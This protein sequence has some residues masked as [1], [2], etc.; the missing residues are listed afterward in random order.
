M[1]EKRKKTTKSHTGSELL[2]TKKYSSGRLKNTALLIE[3]IKDIKKRTGLS[4]VDISTLTGISYA[5]IYDI[6]KNKRNS[7]HATRQKIFK[8]YTKILKAQF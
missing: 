1:K 5:Y 4:N 6:L 3:V 2:L 7:I 8:L